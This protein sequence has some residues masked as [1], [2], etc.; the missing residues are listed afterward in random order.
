MTTKVYLVGDMDSPKTNQWSAMTNNWAEAEKLLAEMGLNATHKVIE[1]G[2]PRGR[3][4][5]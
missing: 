3:K 4:R 2:P 1:V 5:S